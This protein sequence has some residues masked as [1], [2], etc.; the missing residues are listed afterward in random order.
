MA[1][2]SSQCVEKYS[3]TVSHFKRP[4]HGCFGRLSAQ[5]SAVT[6][7][8]S[9]GCSEMCVTDKASPSLS[10]RCWQGNL[11]HLQQRFPSSAGKNGPVGMLKSIHQTMPFL[12]TS[13]L[14]DF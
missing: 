12:C 6:A 13:K 4:H 3:S 11:E 1:S 14:A 10:V 9:F 2:N 8:K 7:L 5:V